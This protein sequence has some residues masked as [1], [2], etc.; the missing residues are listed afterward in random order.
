VDARTRSNATN[1][2]GFALT[3]PSDRE[4]VFTRVFDAPAQHV[5]D[6]WTKPEHLVRWYGCHNSSLIVCDVDLRIGG[7]FH[8]VARLND[9]SKHP[10]SGRYREI[11]PPSRLVFTERFNNDPDKE[12]LVTLTLDEHGGKTTLTMRA[13]YRS[14]EDRNA[15]LD[16][17]VEKGFT[18]MLERLADCLATM[19]A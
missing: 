14:A 11:E 1:S 7:A 12:A 10:I 4:I 5:F 18:E 15:V 16:I 9:G 13:L 17:G 19:T 6:A 8:F 2:A 3:M